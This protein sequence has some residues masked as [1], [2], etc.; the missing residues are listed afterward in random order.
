MGSGHTLAEAI[1]KQSSPTQAPYHHNSILA[2]VTL[3]QKL[4]TVY[5]LTCIF[6]RNGKCVFQL[7]NYSKQWE[8]IW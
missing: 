7:K 8:N 3:G 4:A 6:K 5:I 2:H 1:V